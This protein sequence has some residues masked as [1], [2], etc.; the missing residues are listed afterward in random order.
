MLSMAEKKD[1]ELLESFKGRYGINYDLSRFEELLEKFSN[2][3][4]KLNKIVHVAGTNGKGSTVAFMEA[5]LI[6]NGVSVGVFSSPHLHVYNERFRFNGEMISDEDFSAMLNPV[7]EHSP[8]GCT[9]FE[10][11][12]VM[13]FL[14]FVHKKPD[15]ILLEAGL[16]G[17]LDTTNVVIPDVSVIT[18]IGLDHQEFLGDTITRVTAEKIGIIKDDVPLVSLY[19]Q[20]EEARNII[21]QTCAAMGIAY[22]EVKP[23]I[24]P[25]NFKL[26]G[27]FQSENLALARQALDLVLPGRLSNKKSADGYK[28]ATHAGRFERFEHKSGTVVMD[29][30]HNP[31]AI[32][33][34][35][36]TMKAYYSNKKPAVFL[37]SLLTKDY[38]KMCHLLSE[39]TDTIYICNFADGQSV[40]SKEL[41]GINSDRGGILP[42][43]L[44]DLGEECL[45][46]ELTLITG[47]IYFLSSIYSDIE[48]LQK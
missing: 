14:Y 43:C 37:G 7:L 33:A 45:K 1:I 18:K 15:V 19:T 21:T 44:S 30:A 6:E 26:Q 2:P 11:L 16:G 27:Q 36:E 42:V 47:S 28:K 3:H 23:A 46:H 17:L 24:L 41:E 39:Y 10:L 29:A 34:L 13:A 31:S 9:E 5:A 22:F 48:K 12:T 32:E 38:K 20:P 4:K 25:D 8:E 35:I 40:S